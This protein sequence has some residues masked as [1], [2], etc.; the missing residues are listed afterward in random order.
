MSQTLPSKPSCIRSSSP[1]HA[2]KGG[3]IFCANIFGAFGMSVDNGFT[4]VEIVSTTVTD[5]AR[6]T[7]KDILLF[8]VI[9]GVFSFINHESR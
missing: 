4:V 5:L 8:C 6:C 1:P 7:K 9:E 2:E 3:V